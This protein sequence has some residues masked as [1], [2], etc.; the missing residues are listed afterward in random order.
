MSMPSFPPHGADMT[1][2]E[3]LTM[4]IASIAMEELALSHIL[5]AEGEKLQYILKA[6]PPCAEGQEILEVNR[7]VNKLLDTVTQT[8]ILLKG[9]L[10]LALEAGGC[11]PDPGPCPS[12][13]PPCPPD[14]GPCPSGPPPCPPD[15]GPCPPCPPPCPPDPGPCPPSPPPCPPDPGPFPPCPPPCRERSSIELLSSCSGLVWGSGCALPWKRCSSQG[16]AIRW[17]DSAPSL[18]QL[19]ASKTYLLRYT[20]NTCGSPP[21]GEGGSILLRR[22]PRDA[23]PDLLPLHFPPRCPERRPGTL[24]YS[25]LL[26]PQAG[27]AQAALSLVLSCSEGLFI[28]RAVLQMIEL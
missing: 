14:L 16:C 22:T 1:R 7:S 27:P 28:E 17:N 24:Q 12:G 9:K 18:I 5:N 6:L 25:T 20:I 8:Q 13:P 19:D 3:A 21:R 11:P 2:E 15:P 26:L 10:A 4:I 23:Y